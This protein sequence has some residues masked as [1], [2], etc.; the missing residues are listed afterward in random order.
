MLFMMNGSLLLKRCCMRVIFNNNLEE[1]VMDL[2][3]LREML[4]DVP[5]SAEIEFG[6]IWYMNPTNSEGKSTLSF[7]NGGIISGIA[8]KKIERVIFWMDE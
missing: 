4:K 5:D 8:S 2:G 3:E 1:F 6:N 7:D